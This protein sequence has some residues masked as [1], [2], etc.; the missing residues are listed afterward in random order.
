MR[1]AVAGTTAGRWSCIIFSSRFVIMGIIISARGHGKH[2][3][4][5]FYAGAEGGRLEKGLPKAG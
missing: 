4:P 1:K 3:A 2:K 5:A